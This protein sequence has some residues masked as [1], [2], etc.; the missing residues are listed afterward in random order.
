MRRAERIENVFRP[1][2][3]RDVLDAPLHMVAEVVAGTLHTHPRPAK[4]HAWA[5]SV[6]GIEIGEPLGRGRSGPGGWLIIAASELH[7]GK[8]IIVP[9]LAGWLREHVRGYGRGLLHLVV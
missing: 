8:D 3:Y 2:T 1:P 4:R 9:D 6:M 7:L 5:S